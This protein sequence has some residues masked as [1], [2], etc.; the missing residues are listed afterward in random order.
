MSSFS[1]SSH[2]SFSLYSF[3]Q[4]SFVLS[5]FLHF[6]GLLIP[7]LSLTTPSLL[8][9]FFIYLVSF[10]FPSIFLPPSRF[11]HPVHTVRILTSHTNLYIPFIYTQYTS[12]I[13]TP[14]HAHKERMKHLLAHTSYIPNARHSFPCTA[15]TTH[16]TKKDPDMTL[17]TNILSPH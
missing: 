7:F 1:P 13:Y 2:V 4:L 16:L 5:S 8:T 12:Y 11:L 3:F 10:P 15:D 9:F 6:P 17:P 14:Y